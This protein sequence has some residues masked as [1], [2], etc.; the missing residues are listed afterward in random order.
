MTSPPPG[1]DNPSVRL[2]RALLLFAPSALGCKVYDETLLL[3]RDSAAAADLVDTPTPSDL[4]ADAADAT[5]A[6][7][8]VVDASAMDAVDLDVPAT[9]APDV[10]AADAAD[11]TDVVTVDIVDAPDVPPNCEPT[12]RGGR[13][14][15]EPVS[16][17]A[18]R[19][20][21]PR[22]VAPR[23]V[24]FSGNRALVSDVGS[25]RIVAYDL[26]AGARA[27]LRL[28]N[29]VLGATPPAGSLPGDP[30]GAIVALAALPD[31]A[32]ALADETT[33]QVLRATSAR[34]EALPGL[35][36]Q[37]APRGVAWDEPAR[38]LYVSADNRIH[39][40]ILEADGGVGAVEAVAGLPCGMGCADRFN[41]D[42]LP[43][44]S[45][46]LN[47]PAGLDVDAEF[48]YFA[49]RDNCRV[50][51]FRRN[52][53]DRVVS[54]FAGTRCDETSDPFAGLGAFAVPTQLRLGRVTDVKLGADGSVYFVDASRCAVFGVTP[55][56]MPGGD[57]IPRV[58]AGS[59]QGCGQVASAGPPL[60]PLGGLG[61]SADRG[62]VFF[63]DL[64]E[65]RVGRILGTSN[66][67]SPSIDFPISPGAIPAG[68]EPVASVRLGAPG[69]AA[70]SEDGL[71]LFVAAPGAG[72]SYE[73]V[74]NTARALTGDGPTALPALTP[75]LP[76]NALPPTL[77]DGLTRAN[78][79]VLFSLTELGV[80]AE[81]RDGALR[82][83]A[84]RFPER[85][86][87]LTDAGVP[88]AGMTDAAVTDARVT[89]AR[90]T[91]AGATDAAVDVLGFDA[92]SDAGV[93][94]VDQRFD[95]PS[96]AIATAN[97]F[98][99][100]DARGRVWRVGTGGEV[101]LLAGTGSV[102]VGSVPTPGGTGVA[103][104]LAAIGSVRGLA[105]DGAGRV[106]VADGARNIVWSIGLE[107]PPRARIVAGVVDRRAPLT[108]APAFGPEF[109]L[110]SPGALAF[111]GMSTIYIADAEANRVRSLNVLSGQVST[112]AGSGDVGSVSP[113]GDFGDARLA[114]LS[115][116][117]GLA[118][119]SGRLFVAEQGSGRVRV[120]RLP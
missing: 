4:P 95:G 89:D 34:I 8:D 35:S 64:R 39:R 9:D 58:V 75:D 108:D 20:D 66:G 90:V 72:R 17:H 76:P 6:P 84:G 54:T 41:A 63:V 37:S 87:D 33:R 60:G 113:A 16:G 102:S 50:R 116:P 13:A 82:R 74:A 100:G 71:T 117:A 110:A 51:R 31:G 5:D 2:L 18:W 69:A 119:H 103:A 12:L 96:Q 111:D 53:P 118:F 73:F 38:A 19:S 42:G 7:V 120:V 77:I 78:A 79:R 32:L 44:V 81:L 85:V 36:F 97:G 62:A 59:A 22:L 114:T 83:V 49:D 56:R 105:V 52:D 43:G 61:V 99:F 109:V 21:D 88:D 70:T 91:D 14:C 10:T 93:L 26:A 24:V 68:M 3:R 15:I 45:T 107:T 92:A 46:A 67:G 106:F 47:N 94:A 29:G 98:I 55:P 48:V 80:I 23:A 104:T 28:G 112:F 27:S 115:R 30:L 101:A 25:G 11:V 1:S 40:V 65:Q 86:G 57:P